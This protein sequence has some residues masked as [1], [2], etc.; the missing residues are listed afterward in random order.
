VTKSGVDVTAWSNSAVADGEV[1]DVVR[2]ERGRR[3]VIVTG[4]LSVVRTLI[5]H[6]LVDEYRLL[7]FPTAIGT[8][9]RLFDRLVPLS[10]VSSEP[11]GAAVLS[12]LQRASAPRSTP[13]TSASANPSS[14]T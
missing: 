7:T 2:A 3:D 8:G 14:G 1:I 10:F 12:V 4:S 11:A 13:S 9:E 5:D 6:D